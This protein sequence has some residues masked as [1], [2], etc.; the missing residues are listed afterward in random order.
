[1]VIPCYPLAGTLGI[2]ITTSIFPI[3]WRLLAFLPA[4]CILVSNSLEFLEEEMNLSESDIVKVFYNIQD[5]DMKGT[6]HHR[7][8]CVAG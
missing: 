3:F 1:M 5:G 2:L 8:L 4:P 6:P 7:C